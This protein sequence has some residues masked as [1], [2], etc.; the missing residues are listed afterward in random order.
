M[1]NGRVYLGDMSLENPLTLEDT[2]NLLTGW[3]VDEL[4]CEAILEESTLD[5]WIGVG[6]TSFDK[7]INMVIRSGA[8][9][10]PKGQVRAFNDRVDT[11]SKLYAS[12]LAG[13]CYAGGTVT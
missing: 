10:P 8:V 1:K 12:G 5:T 4:T 7:A 13:Y 2:E 6:A 9:R 3:E 11:A